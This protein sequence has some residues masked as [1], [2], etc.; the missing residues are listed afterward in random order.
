MPGS[1]ALLGVTL[2][3]STLAPAP[4]AGLQR[5][6]QTGHI[7]FAPGGN[8]QD[9]PKW[10]KH[11]IVPGETY[12]DIGARY[13]VTKKEILRW[14]K[15]RL[16]EK[17]WLIAGRKLSIQARRLP[18]P[19]EKTSYVV[20][21]GDTW[22]SIA[23]KFGVDTKMFRGV[24]NKR[25]PKKLRPGQVLR[26]WTNPDVVTIPITTP[27]EGQVPEFS[28]RGGGFASGRANRGRLVNGVRLPDSEYYTVR[29]PE[30]AW[31]TSKTVL[32]VQKA[33]ATFRIKSGFKGQVL[34]ADMSQRRGGRIRPHSSH[35]T[36]LDVDIRL[37][38]LPGIAKGKAPTANE[39]DWAASWVLLREFID[40]G[41]VQ[42]IFLSYNRQ[43]RLLH[44][45]RAAGASAN[46]IATHI[47]Y[48]R[49]SGS[50]QGTIRHSKGHTIHFH[51][52]IKCS[53]DAPACVSR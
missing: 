34:I 9:E 24:W 33:I 39:I 21:P 43:K 13:G 32:I 3:A 5:A 44:A 53:K 50:N 42:Y 23:K 2:W 37:P 36:G 46:Y 41:E 6:A 22:S 4:V 52:R 26:A 48:P 38:K 40:T 15:K 20:R 35:Q 31:G 47:Q 18:P 27:A 16:G 14:N 45:A 49:G 17:K 30:R 11:T 10:I 1:T 7:A 12:D 25:A 51:V 8:T 29:K 19:R 28:V